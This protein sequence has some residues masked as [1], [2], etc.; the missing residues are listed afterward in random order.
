MCVM[1]FKPNGK[2]H[3]SYTMQKVMLAYINLKNNNN[4]SIK[5]KTNNNFEK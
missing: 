3:I 2:L 1:Y 5:I 4:K